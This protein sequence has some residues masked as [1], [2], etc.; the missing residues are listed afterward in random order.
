MLLGG[1]LLVGMLLVEPRG[2]DPHM[3]AVA[4]DICGRA[5]GLTMPLAAR[6]RGDSRGPWRVCAEV[7]GKEERCSHCSILGYIWVRNVVAAHELVT[8]NVTHDSSGLR[9]ALLLLVS[10]SLVDAIQ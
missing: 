7:H 5:D 8:T 6:Q 2:G 9:R 1:M 10:A 3:L 4:A